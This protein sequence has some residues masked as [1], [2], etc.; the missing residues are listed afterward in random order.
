MLRPEA[1]APEFLHPVAGAV[2]ENISVDL[3]QLDPGKGDPPLVR[4]LLT[5][6]LDGANPHFDI[7]QRAWTA[8]ASV[9]VEREQR[10]PPLRPRLMSAGVSVSA[11]TIPATFGS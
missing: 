7:K 4:V 9:S 10:R 1:E 5:I 8:L 6:G 3:R 11:A 2:F